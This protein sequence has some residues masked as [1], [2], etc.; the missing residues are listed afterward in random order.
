MSELKINQ[1]QLN[2][3]L[4]DSEYNK[5]ETAHEVFNISKAQEN[6]TV[7]REK[8]AGYPITLRW[9]VYILEVLA[10]LILGVYGPGYDAGSF[11]YMRY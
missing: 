9:C 6:G 7:I 11:I 10:V 3:Q 4:S 2:G 5:S 1:R 8:I